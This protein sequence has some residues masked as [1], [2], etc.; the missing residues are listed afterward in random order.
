MQNI[1][2]RLLSV[3]FLTLSLALLSVPHSLAET[4]APNLES[5]FSQNPMWTGSDEAY[6][7][8]MGNGKAIWLF[9]DT[10]IGT[11]N[12][13]KRVNNDLI[14][15]SIGIQDIPAGKMSFYWKQGKPP[16]SYFPRSRNY[17]LWLGDGVFLKNKLYCFAKRIS[18]LPGHA[19]EPF[20]FVWQQDELIVI[21]NLAAD[22]TS[23]HCRHLVLPFTDKNLHFGT[24]CL[25][26]GDMLFVMGMHEQKKQALL[27]RIPLKELQEQHLKAFEFLQDN[28]QEKAIW[29]KDASKC[30]YLF[31]HAAAEASLSKVGKNFLCILHSSGAG[32]KIVARTAQSLSGTW[33]AEKLLYTIPEDLCKRGMCYAAKGHPEQSCQNGAIIVTYLINPGPLEAH[34]KDP[35]IYFPRVVEIKI[36]D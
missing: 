5:Q 36:P 16:D 34:V 23:W 3:I 24:A 15:N 2:L 30:A 4:A 20:G 8:A 28:K 21:D 9:S 6:S 1:Y 19:G 18:A 11:I 22:P 13:G 33:S 27:A 14:N 26:D 12:G 35:Y 29:S 25:I 31:D 7:I 10:F 32:A 17:W